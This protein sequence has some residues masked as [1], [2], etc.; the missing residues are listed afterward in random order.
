[1]DDIIRLLLLIAIGGF[2]GY[3]TN[4]IAIKMLFRPVNPVKLGFIT[5]Q[6]VF[7]KRKDQMAISL[8]DTIE[9]ELLS[10]P[11]SKFELVN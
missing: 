5:V 6:G 4:K 9:Q 8:A 1:M 3:I 7:P 11:K 10:K 2:I